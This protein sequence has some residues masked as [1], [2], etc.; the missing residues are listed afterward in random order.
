MFVERLSNAVQSLIL[1]F[2][3][4]KHEPVVCQAMLY[5]VS[6]HSEQS[7]VPIDHLH[8]PPEN[9]HGNVLEV[10]KAFLNKPKTFGLNHNVFVTTDICPGSF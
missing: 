7:S 2:Q 9:A 10:N 1:I 6:L 3:R 5:G 4:R 8:A